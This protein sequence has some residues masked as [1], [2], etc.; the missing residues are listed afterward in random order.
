MKGIITVDIGT[1]S[2]RAILYNADGHMLHMDQHES[3]PKFFNDGRVEQDPA[4]WPNILRTVLKS[5]AAVAAARQVEPT[6]ISVTAQRS[7]I[8]PVDQDGVPLHPA[9]MWQDRRTAPLALAM[10]DCNPLVYGKT[11]LKISPVFSAIKMTWLRRERPEVW[12]RTH[13]MI[14]IQDWVLY[15]LSGR[16]VTDQS[17]GSRT[18]LLDLSTR[19]WDP[20]LLALFDVEAR[21][22]CDLVPPGSI[23]GG[24]TS[25]MASETG[26]CEGLP[27][28]SAGGDQQCAALGLGLFSGERAVSN[29]GTGSFLI[30]HADKPSFDAKMRLGCNVSAV[31]GAYIVE[32]AVLTSGTIYRWF[33]ESLV[34]TGNP[35]KDSFEAI[36]AEAEMVPPGA[37]DLLLLP[38]FKGSGA[39]YWDPDSKGVFYNVTL[40]TTR[41][42]MARAILEGIAVEIKGSLELMETLCGKIKSVTVSGG[43]T[44]SDLFNQIQSDIFERPIIRFRNNEATSTGA[45]I[46][47][48][49]ATGLDAS[50]VGAFERVAAG[51]AFVTY[52]TNPSNRETYERQC[53]RSR[54]L[55]QALATPAF[56]ELIR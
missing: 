2:M 40:S 35:D 8:I 29:T 22:L 23:V 37:N 26:L 18:N 47:G 50:Y 45:W 54:A 31:P 20:E 11:G 19:N 30:G 51:S 42:E 5:C 1:T 12:A 27:I 52:Q 32:A 39:P 21:M 7:S 44:K 38:H 13:K 48:A 24:L 49:V 43:M 15:Q 28:V 46:A 6:C 33:R 3:I 10:D 53:R 36:N 17:F 4:T 34:A 14:G 56:R 25:A 41:G 9:I 55:Y 16:F